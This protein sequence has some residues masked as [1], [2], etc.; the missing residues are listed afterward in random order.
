MAISRSLIQTDLG[1]DTG[2]ALT[3]CST[4]ALTQHTIVTIMWSEVSGDI[5]GM[6]LSLR[7]SFDGTTWFNS[8]FTSGVITSRS[9]NSITFA[10][11]AADYVRVCVKTAS[12]IASTSD[13]YVETK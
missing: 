1:I 3:E 2:V 10:A 8:E 12:T 13:I 6:E 5:S 7:V 11:I 9:N 4:A